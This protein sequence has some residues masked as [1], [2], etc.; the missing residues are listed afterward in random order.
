MNELSSTIRLERSTLVRNLKPLENSGLVS[1]ITKKASQA[2]LVQLTEKGIKSLEIAFPYWTQAQQEMKELL[3]E[4]EIHVFSGVLQ[5][6]ES[7][8]P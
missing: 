1:T 3:T 6:L 7:M 8:I 4:E 5:K 2:H